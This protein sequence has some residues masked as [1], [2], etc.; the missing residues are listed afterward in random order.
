M[1]ALLLVCLSC[2][3]T[4]VEIANVLL[5]LSSHIDMFEEMRKGIDRFEGLKRNGPGFEASDSINFNLLIST[6]EQQHLADGS[7]VH[8]GM[9]KWYV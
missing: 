3:F 1:N 4:Y 5:Y 6:H 7:D 2:L 8:I 9:Y